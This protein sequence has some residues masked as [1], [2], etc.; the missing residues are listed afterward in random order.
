MAF[1]GAG[2]TTDANGHGTHVAGIIGAKTNNATGIA[3]A[4]PGVKI[5]PVQVLCGDGNG[6]T[7]DVANGI[8]WAANNG[9]DA[10][11]LSLGG[12]G[13]SQAE[14]SAIQYAAL[15]GAVVVASAGNTGNS[16]NGASYPGAFPEVIAV[17]ALLNNNAKA[18]YSTVD[19]YVDIATARRYR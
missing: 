10:I 15:Q 9:A 16:G 14:R 2:G 18:N 4:A 19:S 8:I 12:S 3:G 13:Q 17:A 11:N 7:S 6:V 5:L 1:S